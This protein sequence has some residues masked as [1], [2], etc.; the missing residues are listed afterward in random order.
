MMQLSLDVIHKAIE[1]HT[2]NQMRNYQ[3]T[4]YAYLSDSEKALLVDAHM[5]TFYKP[6]TAGA[7]LMVIRDGQILMQRGYGLR[8]LENKRP[9][10]EKTQFYL[11]SMSKQ[12][13]AMAIMILEE[14]GLLKYDDRIVQYFPELSHYAS[15][16]T[17]RH[18]L[19]HTS[20]MPNYFELLKEPEE[21]IQIT[22]TRVLE[23]LVAQTQMKASPGELYFY[24][25]SN[26][27]LL[28]ILAERLSN[29]K[30]HEFMETHIFGP[31]GMKD[32]FV[33]YDQSKPEFN[34]RAYGYDF[35]ENQ[36]EDCDYDRLTAGGGGIYATIGDLFLWDQALYT[37]KLVK[38]ETIEQ[39]FISGELSNHEAVGYG[40]GWKMGDFR[41]QR[42]VTH[43]G[44]SRGFRTRIKRYLDAHFS[45]IILC[46][47]CQAEREI[48]DKIAQIYLDEK[49]TCNYGTPLHVAIENQQMDLIQTLLNCGA[50]VY[51]KDGNNKDAIELAVDIGNPKMVSLLIQHVLEA[52][53]RDKAK[54]DVDVLAPYRVKLQGYLFRL[55]I[56]DMMDEKKQI[57]CLM[58]SHKGHSSQ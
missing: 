42:F 50:D 22:N 7:A 27:V 21:A 31:L 19:N 44:S 20:G 32:T 38:R 40:F 2:V 12:F 45:V 33:Y 24:N 58:R 10:T 52:S 47:F 13:T 43:T 46:N 35:I 9:V 17:I 36:F 37:E 23:L 53:S 55:A 34:E 15:E 11:A 28:A 54:A 5:N 26:Y 6:D 3:G 18:L 48:I 14:K 4:P 57:E 25:N 39:A 29:Q 51:L 30:F 16:V 8:D 49:M 41:G 56:N 1:T